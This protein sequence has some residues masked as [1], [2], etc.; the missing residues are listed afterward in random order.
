LTYR[1]EVKAVTSHYDG[2]LLLLVRSGSVVETTASEQDQHAHI[3]LEALVLP[4]HEREV[5]T[6]DRPVELAGSRSMRPRC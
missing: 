5:V 3:V 6:D 2:A 4:D 1:V